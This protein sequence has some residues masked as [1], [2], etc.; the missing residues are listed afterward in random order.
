M[1][2]ITDHTHH[3]T[4]T[5]QDIVDGGVLVVGMV[6]V[7]KRFVLDDA[8]DNISPLKKA[9]QTGRRDYKLSS[10]FG[11][12]ERLGEDLVSDMLVRYKTER[13][14]GNEA[15]A[16]IRAA[17]PERYLLL[18]RLEDTNES[19]STSCY[20]KKKP[21][22]KDKDGNETDEEVEG[23]DKYSVLRMKRRGAKISIDVFDLAQDIIVWSGTH[24][25]SVSE[26]LSYETTVWVGDDTFVETFPYPDYPS[27]E[28]AYQNTA[29]GHVIHMPHSGE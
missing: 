5:Y 29:R 12:A 24:N 17:F 22:K 26:S 18:A 21:K 16:A 4:Y 7:D 13:W 2:K 27:W 9:I 14:I 20:K 15:M 11:L 3:P 8:V 28:S 25:S 19:R 6:D 10:G 23:P 1:T